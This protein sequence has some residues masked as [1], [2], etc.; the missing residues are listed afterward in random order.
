MN[1]STIFEKYCQDFIL[2]SDL[3]ARLDWFIEQAKE[4]QESFKLH[5]MPNSEL[6]SSAMA[7]AYEQVKRWSTEEIMTR[8]WISFSDEL[9]DENETVWLYNEGNKFVALGCRV[10]TGEDGGWL[11]ALSNGNIYNE[12]GK[13][14]S[15]CE[16]DDDYEF[17]HWS[18]LPALPC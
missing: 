2:K 4:A 12:S 7:M 3:I 8:L 11:Y 17:T 6:S 13:I 18:R 1:N 14:V 15:E 5:G 10:W 16:V 9:P